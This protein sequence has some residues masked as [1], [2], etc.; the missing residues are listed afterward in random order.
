[1]NSRFYAFNS[2][3]TGGLS[4]L[5]TSLDYTF[6]ACMAIVLV[7]IPRSQLAITDWRPN[8]RVRLIYRAVK[9]RLVTPHERKV[10]DKRC[11][12]MRIRTYWATVKVTEID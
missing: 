4:L 7:S 8:A 12:F 2:R 6:S 1:M 11:S 5:S 3:Q 10:I 9:S